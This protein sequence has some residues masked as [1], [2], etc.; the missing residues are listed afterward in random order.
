MSDHPPRCTCCG[1]P[2]DEHA[3]L[4]DTCAKAAW[5]KAR[6]EQ[7]LAARV[8]SLVPPEDFPPPEAPAQTPREDVLEDEA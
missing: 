5:W 7:I 4:V 8:L 6:Y 3:G 2:Y 1:T